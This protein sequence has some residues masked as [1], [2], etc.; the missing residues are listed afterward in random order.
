MSSSNPNLQNIPSKN[1]EIRKMFTADEG[2]CLIGSDFSQQEPRLLAHMS[3]DE[4]LIS[5]YIQGKDLYAHIGQLAL[6]VPYEDCLE[7]RPDG[8]V[9][10]EGKLRR[11]KMKAIVL[12]LM[13]GKGAKALSED[14]F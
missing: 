12:A 1:K 10:P 14:Y 9:N 11:N 8:S 4:Q 7:H 5:A 3:G 2:Y 13:Y 6:K